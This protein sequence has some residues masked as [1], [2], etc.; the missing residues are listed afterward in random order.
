MAANALVGR[1]GHS[2]AVGWPHLHYGAETIPA[3]DP[4][5]GVPLGISNAKVGLNPTASDP[6][7]RDVASWGIREGFFV[8]P[9]PG[10]ELA[11][12]ARVALLGGPSRSGARAS[13]QP[14]RD[15]RAARS[16]PPSPARDPGSGSSVPS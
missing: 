13:L 15:P 16:R 5:I 12:A 9:E 4:N 3:P 2:G 1:V 14:A 10:G 7:R 11:L 8:L 6:W